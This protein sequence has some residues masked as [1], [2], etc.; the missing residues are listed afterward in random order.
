MD[1]MTKKAQTGLGEA[2][3]AIILIAGGIVGS[4]L[5]I[6]DII[7]PDYIGD[8]ASKEVYPVSC[9]DKIKEISPSNLRYFST[10]EEAK[11]NGFTYKNC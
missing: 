5:A 2:A 11:L 3:I 10:I 8:T 9:K 7:S 6:Q 1:N 4:A